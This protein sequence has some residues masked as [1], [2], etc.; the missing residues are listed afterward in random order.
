MPTV[1]GALILVAEIAVALLLLMNSLQKMQR[2]I[3]PQY[4]NIIKT[5]IEAQK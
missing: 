5:P 2:D 4:I 1:L 3:K